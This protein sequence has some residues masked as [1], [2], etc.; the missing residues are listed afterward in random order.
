MWT[1]ERK[2]SVSP[3]FRPVCDSTKRSAC[4]RLPSMVLAPCLKARS[5]VR[6]SWQMRAA[7]LL[8]PRS[9]SSSV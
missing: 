2:R 9:F 4:G 5:S 3:D 6:N 7:L 8:Q 1:S